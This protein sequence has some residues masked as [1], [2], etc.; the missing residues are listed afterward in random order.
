MTRLSK[1][2]EE[3]IRD[4]AVC[5]VSLKHVCFTG[6]HML[7]VLAELDATRAEL[8]EARKERDEARNTANDN[9]ESCEGLSQE[10]ANLRKELQA[11]TALTQQMRDALKKITTVT[12]PLAVIM[13]QNALETPPTRTEEKLAQLVQSVEEILPCF[14]SGYTGVPLSNLRAS[15]K[16]WKEEG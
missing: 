4:H 7:E 9:A 2:R 14:P 11:Q 12:N 8:A 3:E 6:A 13:A 10:I 5:S 15:L 1:E 16:D